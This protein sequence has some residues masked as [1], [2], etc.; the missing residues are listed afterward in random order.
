MVSHT[1]FGPLRTN[2]YSTQLLER[3][4]NKTRC[5]PL[6]LTPS[7]RLTISS[8][9]SAEM[10]HCSSWS[11]YC[12]TVLRPSVLTVPMPWRNAPLNTYWRSVIDFPASTLV[13]SMTFSEFPFRLTF[14][15][16][17]LQSGD[18]SIS[19]VAAPDTQTPLKTRI[20]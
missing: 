17:R 5:G 2:G 7:Q 3:R 20:G 18:A 9:P 19:H 1:P 6:G 16:T 4:K 14:R 10:L 13:I 12:R 8:E 15:I 11:K